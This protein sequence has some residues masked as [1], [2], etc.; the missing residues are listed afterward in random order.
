MLAR[1]VAVAHEGPFA[2]ALRVPGEGLR[3][4]VYLLRV[5][6]GETERTVRLVRQ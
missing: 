5:R 6:T 1:E 3:P 2:G 4:G